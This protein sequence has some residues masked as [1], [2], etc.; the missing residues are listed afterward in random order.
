MPAF[1][2]LTSTTKCKALGVPAYCDLCGPE[3]YQ[4]SSKS[5]QA[6]LKIERQDVPAW[7]AWILAF[8]FSLKTDEGNNMEVLRGQALLASQS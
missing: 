8:K 4:V 2:W 3:V 1:V 6:Y 5:R 7:H